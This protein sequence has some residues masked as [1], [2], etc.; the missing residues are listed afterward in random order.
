MGETTD[1]IADAVGKSVGNVASIPE[2]MT[3]KAALWGLIAGVLQGSIQAACMMVID[4]KDFN[5]YSSDGVV[6]LLQSSVTGGF[7]GGLFFLKGL[8]Q[9]PPWKQIEWTG[10]ERR[11]G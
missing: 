5:L 3:W 1:K 8:F 9:H 2:R 6:A 7:I 11:R 10:E 4:H